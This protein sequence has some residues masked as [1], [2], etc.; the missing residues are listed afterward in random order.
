MKGLKQKSW[1]QTTDDK[2]TAEPDSEP[3]VDPPAGRI[4][5]LEHRL[6]RNDRGAR[7]GFARGDH[8]SHSLRR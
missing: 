2:K 4:L 5:E 7:L 3:E 6:P 1:T 8:A